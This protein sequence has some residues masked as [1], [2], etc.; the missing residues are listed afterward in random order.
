ME[1]SF[2]VEHQLYLLAVT[3][4]LAKRPVTPVPLERVPL[5]FPLTV[6]QV[7]LVLAVVN[8]PLSPVKLSQT[9]HLAINPVAR[10]KVSLHPLVHALAMERVVNELA[11]VLFAKIGFEQL[12]QL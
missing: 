6:F 12:L 7:V 5:H 9:L 4:L 10:I 3:V 2:R 1:I 8:I 11:Y